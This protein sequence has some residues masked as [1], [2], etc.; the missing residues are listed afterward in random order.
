MSAC[1]HVTT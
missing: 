1:L